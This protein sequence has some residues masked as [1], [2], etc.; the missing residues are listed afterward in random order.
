MG[1]FAGAPPDMGAFAGESKG[2]GASD[3]FTGKT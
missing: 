3:D 2:F 1:A